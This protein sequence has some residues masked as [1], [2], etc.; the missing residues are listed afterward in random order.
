MQSDIDALLSEARALTEPAPAG[1]G[2]RAGVA[3]APANGKVREDPR[4]ILRLEVPV[5][6]RLAERTM[7]LGNI[8]GLTTGA[9]IEFEKPADSQLD[10]M[11]NNKCIGTGSAVKV[12]ENFGLRVTRIGSVADRIRALG[13]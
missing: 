2:P 9:I 13:P 4:R 11:I 10:L 12:G 1:E 6:V 7:P 5:I 8:L 3:P